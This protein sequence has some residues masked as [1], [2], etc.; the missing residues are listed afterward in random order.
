M[1]LKVCQFGNGW[2]FSLPRE[3]A[4]LLGVAPGDYVDADVRRGQLIVVPK[5]ERHYRLDD[6][7]AGITPEN[8]H[9]AVGTGS[10]VG[11]EAW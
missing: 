10:P 2:F 4:K 7:L 6:L 1:E 11:Q 3:T 8:Q 9:H 5:Q